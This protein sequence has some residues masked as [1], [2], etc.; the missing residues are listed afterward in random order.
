M[1]Y[2]WRYDPIQFYDVNIDCETLA[3]ASAKWTIPKV[4]YLFIRYYIILLAM[5]AFFSE[6][7]QYDWTFILNRVFY[8][9]TAV[10]L[11]NF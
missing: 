4:L 7:L 5:Y 2:I 11:D 3:S 8:I 9:G 6:T 10:F 1:A